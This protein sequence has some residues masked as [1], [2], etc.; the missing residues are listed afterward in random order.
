MAEPGTGMREQ[1]AAAGSLGAGLGLMAAILLAGPGLVAPLLPAS[2][3]P[4]GQETDFVLAL[5]GAMVVVALAA[6]AVLRHRVAAL[7]ISPG[8]RFAAGLGL[9]LLGICLATTFAT[10]AGGLRFGPGGG[11]AAVLFFGPVLVFFQAAA[12]E[13]YFRGWI[14]PVLARAWGVLP[15]IGVTALGFAALHMLGA[16]AAP[17]SFLNLLLGGLFFGTLAAQGGG[18]AGAIGAHFAWNGTEQLV[19]GLDPNPGIGSFGSLLDLDLAG[20][21]AWGGSGEGLNASWAMAMALVVVLVP[22]AMLA[23]TSAPAPA[24]SS[25]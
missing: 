4:A 6:G 10:I 9:G 12:E 18:L 2:W 11:G 17:L 1:V 13:L 7:G 16:A 14:Q 22:L 5:Y 23:R 25:R 24:V 3:S 20:P 8:W 19:F 21:A 15:A